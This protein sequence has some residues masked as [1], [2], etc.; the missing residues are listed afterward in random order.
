MSTVSVFA[1]RHIGPQGSDQQQMLATLGY[2]SLAALS[3]AAVPESIKSSEALN[4][5][6]PLTEE[7]ALAALKRFAKLNHPRVQ[8]IG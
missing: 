4:L 3:D 2:D 7:E 8:M 1:P 6:D 5:P